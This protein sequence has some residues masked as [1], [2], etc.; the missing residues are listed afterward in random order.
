VQPPSGWP[1]RSYSHTFPGTYAGEIAFLKRWLADRVNF[2]VTNFLSRPTRTH[3]GG[4]VSAGQTLTLT[5]AA[6]TG[7]Q[8]LYTLNGTDPRLPGGAISPAALS[9]NGPV[10]L[11]LTNNVR[12]FARSWNP[13]HQNLT[14]TRNPPI[15][16]PWS[17]PSMES[18]YTAIPEL[19]VTEIMYHPPSPPAGNTNDAD[20][21]EF[22]EFRTLVQ[23]R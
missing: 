3:T 23:P 17:G 12:V 1:D 21:F 18:F 15:S 4:L 9:N 8:L 7:S 11:T 22:I 6:K 2:I 20:N 13:T 14:G 10:T 5:P 19:R 16:S